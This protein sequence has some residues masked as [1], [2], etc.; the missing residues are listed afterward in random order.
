MKNLDTPFQNDPLPK[1]GLLD[2]ILLTEPIRVLIKWRLNM[3]ID[4]Y[5]FHY[6]SKMLEICENGNFY[7]DWI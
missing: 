7:H 4:I 6:F 3:M 1:S 2:W 5:I